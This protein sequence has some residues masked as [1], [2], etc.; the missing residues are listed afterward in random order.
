[1]CVCVCVCVRARVHVC[2]A[3]LLFASFLPLHAVMFAEITRLLNHIMAICTHILDIG[4]NTPFVWLFEEREKVSVDIVMC[5]C[6]YVCEPV[7]GCAC[8]CECACM[9][10]VCV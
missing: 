10:C 6:L 3:S 8:T 2:V 4:A 9:L 1:M 7:N 5:A